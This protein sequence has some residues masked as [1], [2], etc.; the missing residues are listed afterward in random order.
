MITSK[1]L[2]TG[3]RGRGTRTGG[4]AMSSSCFRYSC[5]QLLSYALITSK[6]STTGGSRETQSSSEVGDTEWISKFSNGQ[7]FSNH[8][9]ERGISPFSHYPAQYMPYRAHYKNCSL[10]SV[11]LS[12]NDHKSLKWPPPRQ[13]LGWNTALSLPKLYYWFKKKNKY[14]YTIRN[15]VVDI[16]L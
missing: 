15:S 11:G 12:K 6:Y 7:H 2:V 9:P 13:T 14:Q 1:H 8:R 3:D 10:S 16:F 5:D 4:C